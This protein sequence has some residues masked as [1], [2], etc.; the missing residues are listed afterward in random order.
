ML[1]WY[2]GPPQMSSW[3]WF[4]HV[5]FS[6]LSQPQKVAEVQILPADPHTGKKEREVKIYFKKLWCFR[7]TN[8][9]IEAGFT[10]LFSQLKWR[11]KTELLVKHQVISHRGKVLSRVSVICSPKL[12]LFTMSLY[13]RPQSTFHRQEKRR[14]KRMLQQLIQKAKHK[15]N[16]V[17]GVYYHLR[18]HKSQTKQNLDCSQE[19]KASKRKEM[20]VKETRRKRKKDKSEEQIVLVC[21]SSSICLLH[22]YLLTP[23]MCEGLCWMLEI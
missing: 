10:A 6:S 16:E 12:S 11:E 1:V 2:N 17:K 23:T 9:T 14:S 20:S 21:L 13:L 15:M 3:L 19:T 7:K 5:T 4:T 18:Q 8:E 22:K